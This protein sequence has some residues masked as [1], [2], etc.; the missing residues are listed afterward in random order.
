MLERVA[1]RKAGSVLLLW[2]SG[3]VGEKFDFEA[4]AASKGG[5]R[6]GIFYS[7]CTQGFY[8]DVLGCSIL[9]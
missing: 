8:I 1:R 5:L 3:R 6:L 2:S 4:G 7:E 9:N